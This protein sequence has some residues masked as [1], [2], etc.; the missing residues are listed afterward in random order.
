MSNAC[1]P[2]VPNPRRGWRLAVFAGLVAFGLFGSA[3]PV[4]KIIWVVSLA[5]VL[6]T[7]REGRIFEGRFDRR[8]V[9]LFFPRRWKQWSL[10]QFI[11]IE[12]RYADPT[13]AGAFLPMAFVNIIYMLWSGLFDWIFPWLGGAYELRLKLNQRGRVLAWKGNSAVHFEENLAI[14][15]RATSLPP[16]RV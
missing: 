4:N 11:A 3:T 10:D 16:R 9:I 7:Y 15:E 5:F 12:T 8:M 13:A 2:L 1:T 14:L 6:G